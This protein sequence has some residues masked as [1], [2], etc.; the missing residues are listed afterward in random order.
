MYSKKCR[1]GQTFK[2]GY[3]ITMEIP[4]EEP[5]IRPENDSDKNDY[6]PVGRK[7]T[8]RIFKSL[9]LVEQENDI[10]DITPI[11]EESVNGN[12]CLALKTLLELTDGDIEHSIHFS[13]IWE[14]PDEMKSNPIICFNN[15]NISYLDEVYEKMCLENELI[16]N[17]TITG[18]IIE[19]KHIFDEDDDS[20]YNI[21]IHGSHNDGNKFDYHVALNK[22]DYLKACRIHAESVAVKKEKPI[23]L[24]GKLRRT[25]KKWY[26]GSYF[27]FEEIQDM[28]ANRAQKTK[29]QVQL[30]IF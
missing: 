16:N 26:V 11:Y 14:A 24:S 3:G 30:S 5:A 28:R 1:I 20:D 25:K 10:G 21:I 29:A 22:E 9:R 17:C 23:E 27:N 12:I 18:T 15:S 2:G 19:L 4:I 13:P 8:E 6:T 7:I